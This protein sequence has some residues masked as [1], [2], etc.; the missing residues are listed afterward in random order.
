M[1]APCRA[2]PRR[3]GFDRNAGKERKSQSGGKATMES[4]RESRA[5]WPGDDSVVRE[6]YPA[7]KSERQK[8]GG[9]ER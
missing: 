4:E 8:P 6:G 1:A 9:R 5:P 7:L 2:A 3:G